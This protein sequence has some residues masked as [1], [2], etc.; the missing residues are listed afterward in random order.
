MASPMVRGTVGSHRNPVSPSMTRV[1]LSPT[2]LA[3]T[4][5]P[6]ASASQTTF[7]HPS[8]CEGRQTSEAPPIQ[9]NDVL[10]G[11]MQSE[12]VSESMMTNGLLQIEIDT[13]QRTRTPRRRR[14]CDHTSQGK[15][16]RRVHCAVPLHGGQHSGRVL[17]R[18][19]AGEHQDAGFAGFGSGFPR[20]TKTI[21][22]HAVQDDFNLIRQPGR[23][24]E[25]VPPA[26]LRVRY[27]RICGP[28]EREPDA[29]L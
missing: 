11:V 17:L 19:I 27:D 6:L 9:R 3:T 8:K 7:E 15:W 18:F 28:M 2:S 12:R 24:P 16:E 5:T 13:R 10:H 1:L 21:Q 25:Q 29:V 26:L 4:G 14:G 22:F 23:I 20:G